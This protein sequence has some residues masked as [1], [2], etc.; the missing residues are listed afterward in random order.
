MISRI[1]QK[2][3]NDLVFMLKNRAV[4]TLV[5]VNHLISIKLRI[6]SRTILILE[7]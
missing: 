6:L 7:K 2:I 4:R 3:I 1:F 5:N